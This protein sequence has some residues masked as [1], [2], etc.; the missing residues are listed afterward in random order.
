MNVIEPNLTEKQLKAIPII[1][2]AKNVTE[3]VK[4]ARTSKTTFYE[5]LKSPGFK[6]EFTR[7][8]KEVIELALHELKTS[9][10]EAVN[11]LKELLRSS[12][13]G[14]RLRASTAILDYVGKFIEL[15]DLEQRLTE[16]ER[17]LY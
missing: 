7:Q 16:I 17:K 11:V 5:W 13:E 8:R 15:E 10:S 4:R 1:L 12:E 3:G 14:I 6:E 2:A 9:T